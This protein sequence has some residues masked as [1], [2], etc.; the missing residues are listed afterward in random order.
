MTS[1]RERFVGGGRVTSH[2]EDSLIKEDSLVT[3]GAN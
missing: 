3:K 2:K 1:L